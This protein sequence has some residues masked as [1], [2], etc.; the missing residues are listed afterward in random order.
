MSTQQPGHLQQHKDTSTDTV[1]AALDCGKLYTDLK[2]SSPT[3]L[4]GDVFFNA[5]IE[6][7]TKLK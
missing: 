7:Q 5:S 2:F 1:K 4:V 3:E 6:G